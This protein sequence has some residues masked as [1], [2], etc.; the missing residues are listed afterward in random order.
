MSSDLSSF[1]I[2]WPQDFVNF[3]GISPAWQRRHQDA[4]PAPADLATMMTLA[5]LH[6]GRRPRNGN[7]TNLIHLDAFHWLVIWP[8]ANGRMLRLSSSHHWFAFFSY[9]FMNRGEKAHLYQ[10]C[11]MW[12]CCMLKSSCCILKTEQSWVFVS[13]QVIMHLVKEGKGT[14]NSSLSTYNGFW[15]FT[16]DES[17]PEYFRTLRMLH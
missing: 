7:S 13:L 10:M 4:L 12:A 6:P 16:N 17:L 3:H 5:S 11:L 14:C 1:E 9:D 15:S 2:L 8:T